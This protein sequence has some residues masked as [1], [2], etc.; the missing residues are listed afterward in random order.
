PV[1]TKVENNYYY[2]NC[3]RSQIVQYFVRLG[4]DAKIIYPQNV[5]DE[6]YNFH[7]RALDRYTRKNRT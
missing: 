6:V 3:S 4:A 2:F 1:P 7:R 5:R